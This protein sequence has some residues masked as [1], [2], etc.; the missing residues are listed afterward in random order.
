MSFL[1]KIAKQKSGKNLG[2]LNPFLYK[3]Y[4][5]CP[6]CFS[7]ITV[8]D[9]ICTENGCAATCQASGPAPSTRL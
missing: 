3:M 8:G 4:D 5:D 1:N 7:D 9:N 2:F 6:Q